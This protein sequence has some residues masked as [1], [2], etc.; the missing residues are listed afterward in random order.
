MGPPRHQHRRRVHLAVAPA[1][2]AHPYRGDPPGG[3]ALQPATTHCV[4]TGRWATVVP[5]HSIQTVAEGLLEERYDSGLTALSLATEHPGRFTI[6]TMLGTI[7]DAWMVYG[8]EAV[9]DGGLVAWDDSPFVRRLR[10]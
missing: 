4:D 5:E 2:R 8:R 10:R 7:D 1:G 3:I 9:A 6:D